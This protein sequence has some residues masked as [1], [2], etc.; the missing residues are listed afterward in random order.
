MVLFQK[1]A[2]SVCSLFCVLSRA[3]S[4]LG[5]CNVAQRFPAVVH[6]IGHFIQSGRGRECN[7]NVIFGRLLNAMPDPA[8]FC[9]LCIFSFVHIVLLT[10]QYF[11][12]QI[13]MLYSHVALLFMSSLLNTAWN[14][15]TSL[16][17]VIGHLEVRKK[18]TEYLRAYFWALLLCWN[19]SK[20]S[21]ILLNSDCYHFCL[22]AFLTILLSTSIITLHFDHALVTLR[23][24]YLL[25][26]KGRS[27]QKSISDTLPVST[28]S[29][30]YTEIQSKTK[31]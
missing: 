30:H 23:Y 6:H 20:T 10:S 28:A 29:E 1:H 22:V 15:F 5:H 16:H 9:F 31:L 19:Y 26:L 17:S 12:R 7:R 25:W 11:S 14:I 2:C 4:F 8:V 24:V 21:H 27:S 13:I 18:N 3:F